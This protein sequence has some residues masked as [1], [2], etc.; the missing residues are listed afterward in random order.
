MKNGKSLHKII[1]CGV[2]MLAVFVFAGTGY[3]RSPCGCQTCQQSQNPGPVFDEYAE[4]QYRDG[5]PGSRRY[6][7]QQVKKL[8]CMLKTLGYCSGA[9][10]GWYGSST[11]RAVMLFLADNF[12]EIGY[13][14]KVTKDQWKYMV[15]WA[16]ERC[17]KYDKK[18]RPRPSYYQYQQYQGYQ[19][20]QQYQ[21]Y[22]YK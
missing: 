4:L 13:G 17:S 14:K 7:R 8:Q 12:Q 2:I 22:Q 11:A 10:D 19:Q 1:G 20:G 21:Y 18:E 9:I 15:H 5:F 3:T 16:G 6:K